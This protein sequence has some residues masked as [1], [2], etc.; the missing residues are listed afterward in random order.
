[1]SKNRFTLKEL[2]RNEEMWDER[3]QK[4]KRFILG[5]PHRVGCFM[6]DHS[7]G[8]DPEAFIMYDGIEYR[9]KRGRKRKNGDMWYRFRCN[10][11]D[12]GAVLLV[13]WDGLARTLHQGM[14][15]EGMSVG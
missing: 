1:M 6:C 11:A 5:S 9:D 10:D 13:R 12:C 8:L 15:K 4:G 2:K 7:E 14:I 3:Y